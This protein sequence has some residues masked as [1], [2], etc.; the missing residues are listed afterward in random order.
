M[1]ISKSPLC[2]FK[3]IQLM[4]VKALGQ[5]IFP[6]YEKYSNVSKAYNDFFHKLI[7][8]VN[9]IVPLK[10]VRKK[11][12]SSEWS[13]SETAEKLSVRDK[14]F[15]KFK[16]SSLNIDWEINKEARND[17]QRL[18]QYKK[19]KYFEEKLAKNFTIKYMLRK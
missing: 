18:I 5:M 16:L 7:E 11:N 19:K 10:T 14:L 2:H 12:A 15:K 9:R 3:S 1:F 6:N 13:D 4:S 8:V 17:V